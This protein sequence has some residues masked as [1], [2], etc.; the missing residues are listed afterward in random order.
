MLALLCAIS[1]FASDYTAKSG[2]VALSSE[3]AAI[4]VFATATEHR[5]GEAAFHEVRISS[6]GL[7]DRALVVRFLLPQGKPCD[8]V[9]TYHPRVPVPI[10][11]RD[12]DYPAR[13]SWGSKDIGSSKRIST[14]PLVGVSVAGEKRGIALGVEMTCPVICR[15]G[16]DAVK[17]ALYA[18]C[19]I[20][21]APECPTAVVRLVSFPFAVSSSSEKS[22]SASPEK[23]S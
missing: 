19:D 14:V 13:V 12:C 16:F 18:E 10:K 17:N 21:L 7:R 5:D 4:G 11:S 1:V 2:F 3:P 6:D 23:A 20:G 15:L 22:P 9:Y 8:F